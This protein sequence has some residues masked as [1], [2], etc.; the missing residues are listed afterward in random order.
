MSTTIILVLFAIIVSPL[1]IIFGATALYSFHQVNID[2]SAIMIEFYRMASAP[3]LITIPLFTFAG[4]MMAESGTPKRLVNVAQA[5]VGW[6]PGGLALVTILACAFFTA[7]TGASGVTIIALGGL[8]YPIL[9]KEKYP[10]KFSMGLVTSCGS[11]GLLFP[12]SLPLILYGL[13]ASV[14]I[15][16]LFL[17]G[18]L[19]GMVLM[20]GLCA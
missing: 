12:P 9:V 11:L 10:D 19:P 5:F 20:L 3:T 18:I 2:T 14:S 13:I 17:A 7:F 1:F 6:M 16:K 8:L 4:Y 15:D